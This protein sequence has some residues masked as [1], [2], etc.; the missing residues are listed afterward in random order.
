[1]SVSDIISEG[2]GV[3]FPDM[4]RAEKERRV[5][6]ALK[7]VNLDPETR[8]RY[9]HEFSGGQRQRIAIARAIVLEPNFIVL[10]E[11]TSALDMLIQAQIVDLLRDIQK[12]RKLTYLFIS[13][14][15]KVV[16]ALAS[17]L[18]V[19]RHGKVME[20]RPRRRRVQESEDRLHPRA[21]RRRVLARGRA[22][23]SRGA[24][25]PRSARDV[26]RRHS[27]RDRR[28][29]GRKLDPAAEA[30]RRGPRPAAVA[31]CDRRQGR[32]RLCDGL[33]AATRPAG[34]P[35][36]PEGDPE[37]R[38][39]RRCAARRSDAAAMCHSRARRIPI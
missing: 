28:H 4:T 29:P 12:R 27:G 15:L 24:V 1:M 37:H 30:A 13:H 6:A 31:R 18:V 9:P 36:E 7:D 33:A 17:R 5:L 23:R 16:A 32:Y 25:A 20:F 3:H 22:R 14:D 39:R 21:V 34:K 11:P 26:R 19:M 38:R 10:D 35:A 8:N 2:L